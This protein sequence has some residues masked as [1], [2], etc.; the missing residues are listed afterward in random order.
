MHLNNSNTRGPGIYQYKKVNI[1]CRCGK[2]QIEY[3]I[4]Q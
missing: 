2:N 4:S 1:L 3:E